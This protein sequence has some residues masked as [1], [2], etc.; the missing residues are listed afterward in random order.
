LVKKE[1]KEEVIDNVM[2]VAL[3]AL[4]AV[5][6]LSK[7]QSLHPFHSLSPRLPLTISTPTFSHF[8]P[9][10]TTTQ[11]HQPLQIFRS[12]RLF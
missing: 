5:S 12:M 9:P 4:R 7:L 3:P 2:V 11:L 8:H 1:S 6:K 10:I